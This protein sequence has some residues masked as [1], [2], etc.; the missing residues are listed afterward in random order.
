MKRFQ[1]G[2]IGCGNIY[3][4]HAHPLSHMPETTLKAVCDILPDR[5]RA[6]ADLYG[7]AAYTDYKEMIAREELDAVHVCLPHY[8][9]PETVVYALEQGLD[10]LTEK[11]MSIDYADALRMRAAA[12]R[13]GRRLGVIFQNRYNP[14]S[15]LIRQALQ[16][17]RL[18][19]IRGMRCEVA[20]RRD[21]TYYDSADWRGRW[22]T[23]GGGVI[24]N[25]AIHTLDLMRWLSGRE[26]ASASAAIAH[27]G[28]TA[29]E[30]E[31]TAEGLIRFSDGL[32]GLFYLT[33]NYST[34]ARTL[35]E[36][37]CEKGVARLEGARGVLLFQDGRTEQ[38]DEDGAD[39]A[40]FGGGKDYWG[41]SHY[42]QIEAFYRDETG[43][44]VAGTC[45]EALKTQ[46]MICA[47]YESAK[48]GRTVCL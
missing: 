25:Q 46:A 30:V 21:Q 42:R 13:T 31:D 26:V 18:G 7:C 6:A 4:M 36:L 22:D 27:R 40:R 9:H 5:A 8:L 14:G 45:T 35:L 16:D 32:Q 19:Q 15:V 10:V 38:A 39:A 33:I 11:P 24:I 37:D 28:A 12:S 43:A 47:I 44:D 3:R 29:V 17:G 34:D 41:F 20:W 1:V 2:I 48:T 23:E